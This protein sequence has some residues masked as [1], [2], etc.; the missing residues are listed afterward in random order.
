MFERRFR[1]ERP[2]V[3]ILAQNNEHISQ[4]ILAPLCTLFE[5]WLV[6]ALVSVH[7]DSRSALNASRAKTPLVEHLDLEY[8]LDFDLGDLDRSF[9]GF[10]N[11]EL[12]DP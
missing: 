9:A 2:S 10:A 12:K 5:A 4:S 6:S 3:A 1:I 7:L 11:R 8:H